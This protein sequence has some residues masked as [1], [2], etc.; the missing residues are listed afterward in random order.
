MSALS[1]VVPGSL[2]ARRYRVHGELGRGGMGIVYLCVDE[3][4][5]EKV[6]LKRLFRADA[7][8]DPEDVWWFQMEARA[9]AALDHP[10]IVRGR[11][12]GILADGTPFLVMDMATGRS[13]LGWLEIA[14]IP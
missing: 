1:S 7:K 9:V 4:S 14:A 5:G 3:S 11:D 12:F 8:L 6:A 2:I 10:A 13:L